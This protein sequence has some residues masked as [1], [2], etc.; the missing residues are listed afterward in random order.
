MNGVSASRRPQ[1]AVL[2]ADCPCYGIVLITDRQV[3]NIE[4]IVRSDERRIIVRTP[5]DPIGEIVT[6][7]VRA[8]HEVEACVGDIVPVGLNDIRITRNDG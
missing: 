8:Q 4:S 2:T 3:T 1:T 5:V 6:G 7:I